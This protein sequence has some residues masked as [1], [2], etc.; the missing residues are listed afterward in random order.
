MT[1]WG[2]WIDHDGKGCPCVGEFV[3]VVAE[4]QIGHIQE[5]TTVAGSKGGYSWDWRWFNE[6]I[7]HLGIMAAR[8]LRYRI[9]KPRGL[10]LLENLIASLPEK[11]GED[12]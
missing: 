7:P 9:R 1:E 4:L 3:H 8:I 10:I 12:A 6:P 2:P 11:I 5:Y